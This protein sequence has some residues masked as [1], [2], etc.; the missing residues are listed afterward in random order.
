MRIRATFLAL[1]CAV[2]FVST[3]S[4]GEVHE[5][6]LHNGMKVF[7]KEDH[8]APVVASM[9][10]YRVGS[11][12]EHSGI[13]GIS[14]MLEHMMF[15]GTDKYGPGE[16]SRIIAENGGKENA[17]TSRDYT[18]YF[19]RLQKDRLEISMK[20]EADRMRHLKVLD[21]EFA[22]EN[23]VVMEERRMRTEDNPEAVTY[24][25]FNAIAQLTSPYHWPVIGW[26]NDIKHLTAQDIRDWYRIW[27]APNNA[28]LVVAGDVDPDAVF[29]MAKKY[30]GPLK[31]MAD[32]TP[33][34]PAAEIKQLGER[35]LTVKVPAE[36]PYLIMGYKAPVVK[37]G[38]TKDWEPYALDVLANVLD[39]GN[40]AR[41]AK[42]LIRG[43]QVAANAGA[44]YSAFARLNGLF[45]F[46]GNPA[47]GHTIDELEKAIRGEIDKVKTDLVSE[48]E[49]ARIK[50]Q[51]IAGDVYQQD[52]VFY[53]AMK[54]GQLVTMGLDWRLADEYADRIQ[55]VTPEQVRDVARKYL[56]DDH[57]T[58]AVLDPLPL[59]GKRPQR[60]PSPG[61]L[62]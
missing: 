55:Q 2:L 61:M 1:F 46:D 59:D 44:G 40:S 23:Q 54:I 6:R 4:A 34:K 30:F 17:F 43:Q 5:Y 60:P 19:Q 15:K 9:V 25:N 16:F 22:K 49:L 13:T 31:P 10:W 28:S 37:A 26:M 39:G 27:Y 18:A 7:V 48:D 58:V 47:Q 12:Y 20:M 24:E 29:A 3:A 51:V 41:F 32:L 53:Q 11:S 56:I 35:R 21:K 62:R 33:P 8:R 14:H 50:A 42:D 38:D 52:S 45:T 36:L 57:L